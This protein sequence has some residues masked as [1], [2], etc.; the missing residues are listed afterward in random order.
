MT[1]IHDLYLSAFWRIW[2]IAISTIVV[3]YLSTIGIAPFLHSDEFLILDLGR[4]VLSPDT[5]WSIAW[6]ADKNQP[7]FVWFYL[8]PVLQE[9]VY[10]VFGQYGPRIFALMGACVAATIMVGW[11]RSKRTR[12]IAAFILGLVFILDPLF[13][14]S[15]SLG[16]VDSWTMAL[17]I[18]SCWMLRRKNDLS[19]DSPLYK[20]Q[21]V[22]AGAFMT[23]A[24]F[25]WPSAIFMVPLIF[26][27]LV[28]QTNKMPFGRNRGGFLNAMYFFGLGALVVAVLMIVPIAAQLYAHIDNVIEGITTNTRSGPKE[29]AGFSRFNQIIE[30]LRVFKFSPLVLIIAVLATIWQ[31]NIGL[32]IAG[33]I[34]SVLMIFTV[35]YIQRVQYLLPYVVVAIAGVYRMRWPNNRN[36]TFYRRLKLSALAGCLIWCIGLSLVARTV[37]ALDQPEERNRNLLLNAAQ[38][39]IGPGNHTVFVPNEFYYAAR[40]LGWKMYKP[41]LA[42]NDPLT[43]AIMQQILPRVDYLIGGTLRIPKEIDGLLKEEGLK[44]RGSFYIYDKN[45]KLEKGSNANIMRL[46]NLFSIFRQPYGPYRLFVRE[47]D[48]A[49]MIGKH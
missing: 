36:S 35:V 32:L 37:L 12:P 42:Q 19:T 39:M 40:S 16:R 31:R 5:E 44:Y 38:T 3:I 13:V 33:V 1:I 10:Q 45:I 7:V 6:L 43:P 30:I 26:L 4:I 2:F 15:Y 8:G 21:L 22:L 34:V 41:Y 24:F 29:Q 17:C 47:P 49:G 28:N 27:E 9:G 18:G 11:L 14:Q 20:W 23:I 46:R 25:V 48:Q